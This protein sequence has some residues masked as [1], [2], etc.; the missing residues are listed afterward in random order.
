MTTYN[1]LELPLEWGFV[2][3]KR[4]EIMPMSNEEFGVIYIIDKDDEVVRMI[5]YELIKEW[6]ERIK[7]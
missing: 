3:D 2:K 1:K 7:G 4:I 5:G 6:K